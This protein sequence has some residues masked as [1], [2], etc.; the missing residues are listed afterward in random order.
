MMAK[1]LKD[2]SRDGKAGEIVEVSPDRMAFLL[3]IEAAEPVK[4][5]RGAGRKAG[6]NNRQKRRDKTA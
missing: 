5:A 1:L 4:P 3:S 6:T 2:S